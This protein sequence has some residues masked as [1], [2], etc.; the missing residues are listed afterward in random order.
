MD[1]YYDYDYDEDLDDGRDVDT[2][3]ALCDDYCDMPEFDDD[4]DTAIMFEM[5]AQNRKPWHCTECDGI[6]HDYHYR[7]C[8][9]CGGSG[10]RW[11]FLRIP[12]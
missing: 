12:F 2:N 10:K 11:K 3:E 1:G 9:K 7:T 8:E 4:D 6:G 5:A